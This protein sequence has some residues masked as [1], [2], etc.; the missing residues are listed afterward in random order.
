V[1]SSTTSPGSAGVGTE[2]GR[3]WLLGE[4]PDSTSGP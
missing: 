4:E 2:V 1:T 3:R